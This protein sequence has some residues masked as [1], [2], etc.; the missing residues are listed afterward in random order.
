MI[1]Q[2]IN[3]QSIKTM[4][5]L[6][7]RE[8][9][10]AYKNIILWPIGITSIIKNIF[11]ATFLM[12]CFNIAQAQETN[13]NNPTDEVPNFLSVD[14][15]L[16]DYQDAEGLASGSYRT[17]L[18][19]VLP[20][21]HGIEPKLSLS[22]DSSAGRGFAGFGWRLNGFGIIE[23]RSKG[24][25]TPN[26][27]DNDIYLLDGEE[28]IECSKQTAIANDGTLLSPSCRVGGTHSTK[29]E[30]YWVIHHNTE[31]GIDLWTIKLKNGLTRRYLPILTTNKG[32][33]RWGI[34][35]VSDTSANRVLYD[36]ACIKDEQECYPNYIKYN[37]TWVQLYHSWRDD[38]WTYANGE[39]ISLVH[40][41][42]SHIDVCVCTPGNEAPCAANNQTD[43]ARA[44][45]YELSYE[46]RFN[47]RV[48]LLNKVTMYG[49]DAILKQTSTGGY[50]ITSGTS[51]PAR[52]FNYAGINESSPS[53]VS[54]WSI[55]KSVRYRF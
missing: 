13:P 16:K 22:Y 51:A 18:P 31:S 46:S 2:F 53:L 38:Y 3:Q 21:F 41:R 48:D 11:I 5:F 47:P 19:I 43:S 39:S 42:L 54:K 52:T 32:T 40:N 35:I 49:K 7:K 44:R 25:G 17:S 20:P 26:Y 24:R 1:K 6:Q 33:Y 27:D 10:M 15:L 14:D 9:S 4:P 36:W 30:S 45:I 50:K 23:R 37:G 34:N 29:H 12:L 28:L 8:F 55:T